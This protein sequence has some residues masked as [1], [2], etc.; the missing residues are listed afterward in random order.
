MQLLIKNGRIVLAQE[1]LQGDIYILDGKINR[2]EK[3]IKGLENVETIDAKGQFIL[4]A[5]IDPHVHLS[6]PTANG[7][8]ADNFEFGAKAALAGGTTTFIDF[9]TPRKGQSL[10]DAFQ[11]RIAEAR[12]AVCDYAFHMSIIEWRASM[13]AEIDSCVKNHGITSFKTYLAYQRSVGIS[14]KDLELLMEVAAKL[15]ILITVHAE[16]GDAIDLMRDE[17]VQNKQF[18]LTYH[19]KT[20]PDYTEFEAIEKVIHLAKKTGCK[21]YIVHVSTKESLNKINSA[22]KEGVHIFAETCPQYFTFNESVYSL[23]R[24]KALGF[25]ISPP[26]RSEE[27]RRGIVQAIIAG[28]VNTIGTDHC[29]FTLKQKRNA[30]NFTQ[31]A[32]GTGGIQHR[33]SLFFSRFVKSKK[34]TIN[35]MVAYTASNAAQI[36]RIAKKGKIEIGFDADLI[37]WQEKEQVVKDQK[38]YS[39]SD[40]DIY[41]DEMIF[42]KADTVIKAGKIIYHNGELLTDIPLGK[43]LYRN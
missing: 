23:E 6:L 38:L 21:A 30:E 25:M 40:I 20:R 39:K 36:F 9:I 37:I 42:G 19:P 10:E 12:D 32:N 34:L 13:P 35:Q 22:Q 7:L 3:N 14:F 31:V 27:N 43:Y 8:T 16:M 29:P 11:E 2:I 17:A 26:I 15:D 5:G 1:T 33:L 41:A 28:K 4:P 24:D 18:A